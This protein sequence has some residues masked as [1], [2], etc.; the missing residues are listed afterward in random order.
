M[1]PDLRAPLSVGLLRLTVAEGQARPPIFDWFGEQMAK[2][3]RP[4][5]RQWAAAFGNTDALLI[6]MASPDEPYGLACCE[7]ML[8][9][10][11]APTP[12]TAEQLRAAAVQHAGSIADPVQQTEQLATIWQTV[13]QQI[14]EQLT[15]QVA[16][17]YK[18]TMKIFNR[19]AS[20]GA[21]ATFTPYDLG[22][23]LINLDGA[24]IAIGPE[25]L[26]A[27]L[28]PTPFA[29]RLTNPPQLLDIATKKGSELKLNF[30]AGQ[31]IDLEPDGAG[32]YRGEVTA[33]GQQ[34]EVEL[35]RQP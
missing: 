11:V 3:Q 6:G 16:G 30:E 19:S 24:T 14:A 35:I 20:A 29:I 9:T 21:P 5:P 7:A 2:D 10:V 27:Q 34:V 33:R 15:Q 28:V 1:A 4:A 12:G 26:E 13:Q 18:M 25:P 22:E 8:S 31:P 23:M 32:N 17:K